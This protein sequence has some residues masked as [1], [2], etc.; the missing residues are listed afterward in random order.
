MKRIWKIGENR[1]IRLDSYQGK[2]NEYK[3]TRLENFL[4]FT[5]FTIFAVF[6]THAML[7]YDP[8]SELNNGSTRGVPIPNCTQVE[9]KR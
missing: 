1:Y 7:G 8:Q 2:G 6:V 3:P 9:A 5:F 4:V